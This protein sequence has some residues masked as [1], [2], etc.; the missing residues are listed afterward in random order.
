MQGALVYVSSVPFN[1][2]AVGQEQPTDA[3]GWATQTM[4]R[5]RGFPAADKQRLL[6]MFVRARKPT[7]KVLDATARRLISFRVDLRK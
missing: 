2:F 6:V 3:T 5:L 4:A 1:Q 7:E